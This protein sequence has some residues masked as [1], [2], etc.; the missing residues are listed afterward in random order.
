MS[1]FDRLVIQLYRKYRLGG[2]KE[3]KLQSG[4]FDGEEMMVFHLWAA[5]SH[6]FRQAKQVLDVEARLPLADGDLGCDFLCAGG[7][8][9]HRVVSCGDV[10]Q[11]LDR[12]LVLALWKEIYSL[13]EVATPHRLP[14]VQVFERLLDLRA[15]HLEGN[16]P[17]ARLYERTRGKSHI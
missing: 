15:S 9:V 10:N 2:C 13:C 17:R 7:P 11:S 12:R 6:E 4:C 3:Y 5:Q 1:G 16:T 8:H 14:H